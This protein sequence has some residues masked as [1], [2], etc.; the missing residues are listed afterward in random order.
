MDVDPQPLD[1]DLVT[2]RI[3]SEKIF[4]LVLS[5]PSPATSQPINPPSPSN[6]NNEAPH[7]PSPHAP[8]AFTNFPSSSLEDYLVRLDFEIGDRVRHALALQKQAQNLP[9]RS[10][11]ALVSQIR[12]ISQWIATRSQQLM[13]IQAATSSG[14][15]LRIRMLERLSEIY[16]RLE[17]SL[18]VLDNPLAFVPPIF[19]GTIYHTGKV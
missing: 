12:D 19:K 13:G 15:E 8:T 5:N 3:V 11:A 10:S 17:S 7:P 9:F 4:D 16:A 1:D 2:Q 18:N 14:E 6:N